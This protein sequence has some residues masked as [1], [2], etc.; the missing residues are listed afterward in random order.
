M[1]ATQK[2]SQKPAQ[3]ATQES[4]TLPQAGKLLEQFGDIDRPTAQRLLGGIAHELGRADLTKITR[5]DLCNFLKVPL[6]FNVRGR[7]ES[8]EYDVPIDNKS[9]LLKLLS[10]VGGELF[11]KLEE[12]EKGPDVDS[13]FLVDTGRYPTLKSVLKMI[14]AYDL[15]LATARE[16]ASFKIQMNGVMPTAAFGVPYSLCGCDEFCPPRYKHL[17]FFMCNVHSGEMGPLEH[18]CAH[19]EDFEGERKD[20]YDFSPRIYLVRRMTTQEIKAKLDS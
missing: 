7:I 9:P 14:K 6:P 18:E 13:F 15:K 11:D 3:Q 2:T 17:L 19:R 4:A 16:M 5:Y 12:K 1:N 10:K 8:L 20:A